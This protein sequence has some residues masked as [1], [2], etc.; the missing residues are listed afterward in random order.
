MREKEN[1]GE[2]RMFIRTE[3]LFLRPGWPEDLDDLLRALQ[4][5]DIQRT[6]AIST[7]PR[8]ESEIAEYL[9]RPRDLRLPHFFMY[10]RSEEGAHLVG[11]IGFGRN[12]A[13]V[14]LGYWI[15]PAFRGR[16][17]AGEAL[18]A[19]LDQARLIGHTRVIAAHFIDSEAS[20]RVLEAAGFID[21][22]RTQERFSTGRGMTA[23][24]RI[25]EIDLE[26]RRSPRIEQFEQPLSA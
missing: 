21:S 24:A 22:G 6:V 4:D 19:V 7:L 10:L 2:R 8:S 23:P 18:R 1:D 12:G 17:F 14:E 15:V 9:E 26:R 20:E 11:G 16:G 5:D 13:D 3:R 25:Y